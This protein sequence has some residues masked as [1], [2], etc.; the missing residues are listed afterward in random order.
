MCRMGAACAL[1]AI[2]LGAPLFPYGT[3]TCYF[4]FAYCCCYLILS[5][6]SGTTHR[7]TLRVKHSLSS[8]AAATPYL[9]PNIY[10]TFAPV[11]GWASAVVLL[12]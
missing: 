10:V 4:H 2:M 11:G 1:N 9:I 12:N 7:V 5:R 6:L 3:G 8:V